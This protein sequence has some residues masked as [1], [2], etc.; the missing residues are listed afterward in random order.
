MDI[1]KTNMLIKKKYKTKYFKLINLC[2]IN[3]FN[4]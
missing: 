2:L 4:N 3:K 1:G